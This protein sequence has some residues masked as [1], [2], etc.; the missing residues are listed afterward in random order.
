[1]NTM[2][3]AAVIPSIKKRSRGHREG[4]IGLG[5]GGGAQRAGYHEMDAGPPRDSGNDGVGQ[6]EAGWRS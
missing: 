1:M 4:A 5:A 6:A 3:T 2:I